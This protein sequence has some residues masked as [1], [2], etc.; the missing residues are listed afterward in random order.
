MRNV[1]CK[2]CSTKIPVIDLRIAHFNGKGFNCPSCPR[3]WEFDQLQVL[4]DQMDARRLKKTLRKGLDKGVTCVCCGQY[5]KRYRRKFNSIMACWLI[6]FYRAHLAWPENEYLHVDDA[7]RFLH[8]NVSVRSGDYGKARFW[9]LLEAS[10]QREEGKKNSGLWRLTD[11]GRKFVMGVTTIPRNAVVYNNV[12]HGF[13][14]EEINIG[15]ALGDRFH[16]EELMAV[17]PPI[18]V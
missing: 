8:S 1:S 3:S 17:P 10:E 6:A 15:M 16:Y 12:G 9:G 2:N 14:G 11:D 5:A 13:E 4:L 18:S 7:S